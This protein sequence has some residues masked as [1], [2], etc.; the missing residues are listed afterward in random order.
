V[1][2]HPVSEA[3]DTLRQLTQ[4]IERHLGSRL[5]GLYLFGSLAVGGFYPGKSDLDLFA[6]LETDVEEGAQLE[7]LKDV[8]DRFVSE[9]PAWVERI[10]VSY[11]SR[12]VLQT[13]AGRP[14]GRIA[15]ISPG[16][17][18]HVRDVGFDSTIDWYGVCAKGETLCGPAPLELGPA[19][20]PDAF[21][22][23]V[24]AQLR[25]WP[26][27]ARAPWVAYVPA[28]QGYVVVTL[29][30]A[31]YALDTGEQ[32]TK[33][34]AVAW[35]AATFPEW[36]TFIEDALAEYRAD[37]QPA[38]AELVAFTDEMVSRRA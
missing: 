30:R 24:E 12:S 36:S 33:E 21:K 18:L 13:L 25:E 27:R 3:R 7:A 17:P 16:E 31:L 32:A 22:R 20:S 4:A 8:H 23:A 28:H 9:R 19:V 29:C 5:L 6:I 38:H 26:A 1:C 11:V 2:A 15:V 35:A 37:V 10:E 14:G 34:E